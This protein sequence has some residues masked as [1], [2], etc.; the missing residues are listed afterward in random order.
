MQRRA[1]EVAA[2]RRELASK[3]TNLAEQRAALTRDN[4][5]RQRVH[6]FAARSAT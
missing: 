1:A 2:R 5:L 6:D 4:Q 3:S